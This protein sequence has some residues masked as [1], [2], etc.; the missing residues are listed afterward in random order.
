MVDK[1]KAGELKAKPDVPAPAA[2]RGRWDA[3]PKDENGSADVLGGGAGG[4]VT[5]GAAPR[6]RLAISSTAAAQVSPSPPW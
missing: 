5:P 6:K 4:S 1:A 2:K 3:T